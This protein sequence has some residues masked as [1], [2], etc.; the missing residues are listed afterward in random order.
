MS[1][2][3]QKAG[4]LLLALAPPHAHSQITPPPN[5]APHPPPVYDVVS[6][7]IDDRGP[8]S[9][10]TDVDDGIFTATNVTLRDLLE[11]A[12][13]IRQDIIS[14]VPGAIDS[15]R[16]DVRAKIVEP[17][18]DALHKL[19]DHQ[20]RA[21]LLPI[22][23]ERFHLTARIE[24]KTLPVYELLLLQKGPRFQRSPNQ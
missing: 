3:F 9:S 16:F 2:P 22:L 4:C 6:I 11:D 7:R 18:R 24:T 14:G 20:R 5:P 23:A 13:D 12:F 1:K 15:L 21:M 19:S 10:D 17:D 8:G